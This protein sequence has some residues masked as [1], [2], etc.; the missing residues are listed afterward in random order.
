MRK[1]IPILFL[2]AALCVAILGCEG[3]EGDTGIMGPQ[4]QTGVQGQDGQ[5][6]RDGTAGTTG[7]IGPQGSKGDK[8]DPGEPGTCTLIKYEPANPIPAPNWEMAIPELTLADMPMVSVYVEYKEMPGR[9]IQ[10]PFHL[11]S[12]PYMDYYVIFEGYIRFQGFG[13]IGSKVK[14][15]ILR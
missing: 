11:S 7:Q 4:G 12:E 10:I 8:G 5:D 14:V 3:Q 13:I 15:Y 9:W 1:V 2:V 6:G